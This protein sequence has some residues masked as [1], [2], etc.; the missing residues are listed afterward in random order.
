MPDAAATFQ[1]ITITSHNADNMLLWE[2]EIIRGLTNQYFN[3]GDA[4]PSEDDD[5]LRIYSTQYCPYCDRVI[6]LA[7]LKGLRL[8][9]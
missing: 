3:T 7:K 5:L 1:E 6:I 2:K 4:E 8:I 9:F